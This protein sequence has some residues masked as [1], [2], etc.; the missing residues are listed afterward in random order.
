MLKFCGPA[1]CGNG[2]GGANVLLRKKLPFPGRGMIPMFRKSPV[3]ENVDRE[4]HRMKKQITLHAPR[5]AEPSGRE[6]RTGSPPA[7]HAAAPD[8][9]CGAHN[10]KGVMLQQHDPL[11]ICGG[12]C[13]I[14]T[15]DSL[16][17]RQILYLLS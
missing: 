13:A 3:S 9:R 1:P 4:K 6:R 7:G 16:L 14:R 10:R 5:G 2:R 8:V 12:S 11:E 17:K 15:R